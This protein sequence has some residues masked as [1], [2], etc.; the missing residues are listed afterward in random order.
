[1]LTQEREAREEVERLRA[2]RAAAAGK[3]GAWQTVE[4]LEKEAGRL[5]KELAELKAARGAGG[6]G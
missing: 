2:L 1:L 4:D 3:A 6:E 5:R